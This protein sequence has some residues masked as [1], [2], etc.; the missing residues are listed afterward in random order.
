MTDYSPILIDIFNQMANYEKVVNNTFKY[1]AYIRAIQIITDFPYPINKSNQLKN[2]KDASKK[3][4]I[5]DRLLKKI[6]EII[7][8]GNL[9]ELDKKLNTKN[10][11]NNIIELIQV[12][13]IGTAIATQ[14]VANGITSIEQLR[15][16]VNS[17]EH[18]VTHEQMLGLKYFD[19]LQERIPRDEVTIF[20]N[21]FKST[22]KT[23]DSKLNLK[24][25]GSY[26][27]AAITCGDIDVLLSHPSPRNTYIEEFID[28][29]KDYVVDTIGM[30]P[31]KYSGIIKHPDYE[32]VRRLDIRLVAKLSY[33]TS[34]IYYTGSKN[35]NI[36]LRKK[37]IE[38]GYK[39][40]EYGLYNK[41]PLSGGL[42]S[43]TSEQQL[44]EILDETY[45]TPQQRNL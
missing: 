9:I 5:G 21:I 39:L 14:F 27:R 26:R 8:T 23:V 34:L 31:R 30:G 10:I 6:D 44:F 38:L 17:G 20:K 2:V 7:A 1:N 16:V 19:D 22:I 15:E 42:I 43:I 37:A 35:L 12:M 13:G 18:S 36:K 4:K 11:S 40:N 29:I 25:T 24:I 32:H 45:L 33:Y 41:K 3:F 28:T